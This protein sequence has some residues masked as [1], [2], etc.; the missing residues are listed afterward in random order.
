MLD[1][2]ADGSL[3]PVDVAE[4]GDVHAMHFGRRLSEAQ[5]ELLPAR[6]EFRKIVGGKAELDRPGRMLLRSGVKCERGVAGRELAPERRLEFEIEPEHV[7][8]EADGAIHVG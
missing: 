6:V 5:A 7:A 4:P 1:G 8:M 2:A 3:G